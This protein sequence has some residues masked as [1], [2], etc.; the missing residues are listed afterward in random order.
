MPLIKRVRFCKSPDASNF[1]DFD[2]LGQELSWSFQKKL[3]RLFLQT[4]FL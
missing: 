2:T 3:K 4:W 1:P